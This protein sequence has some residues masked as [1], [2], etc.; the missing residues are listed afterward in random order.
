MELQSIEVRPVFKGEEERYRELMEKHHYLGY[1]P[2]IGETLWYIAEI[3]REWV[4]LISFSVSALKCKA[5]DEWIEWDYRHQY[6]RL[7][8]VVNNNRF[9]ILPDFPH[10]GQAFAIEREF[11]DEKTGKESHYLA[12]RT[13]LP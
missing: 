1:V 5:R 11:T 6:D 9:L 3:K 7:K 8:L 13:N 12:F 2:K 4:S 10:V